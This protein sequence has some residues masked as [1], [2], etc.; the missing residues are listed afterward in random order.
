MIIYNDAP[1]KGEINTN[2]GGTVPPHAANRERA[3]D[4]AGSSVDH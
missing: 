2:T 1:S 4:N 3:I